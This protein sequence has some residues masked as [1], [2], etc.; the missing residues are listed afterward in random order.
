MKWCMSQRLVWYYQQQA[1]NLQ[2]SEY[3]ESRFREARPKHHCGHF[4]FFVEDG[5]ATEKHQDGTATETHQDG[6]ATEKQQDGT[7]T[8]KHQDGTATKKHQ[9]GTATETH[10]DGTAMETHQDGTATETHQDRISLSNVENRSSVWRWTFSESQRA[11]QQTTS[12]RPAWRCT[13]AFVKKLQKKGKR[14]EYQDI[15]KR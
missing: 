10:Q 7:A 9:D 3:D 6:T 5:T 8:K 15:L 1:E 13:M 2:Y 14:E 11:G 4:F 12:R